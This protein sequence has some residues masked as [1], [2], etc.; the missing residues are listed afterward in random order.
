MASTVLLV[1]SLFINYLANIYTTDHA[2]VYVPDI[3]LDNLPVFNVNFIFYDGFAIFWL[4]VAVLL[5]MNPQKI[6][7]VM[8]STA[9]FILIRSFFI[10]LT[11]LGLPPQHSFL[12]PDSTFRYMT[13][14][15]DMFFSSHTGLPFLMGL[16]FWDNKK[17]RAIFLIASAVF[18]VSV[19]LGHLHYSIDVFAAFFIAY[20]IYHISLKLFTVDYRLFEKDILP[21][22]LAL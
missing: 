8:K 11:H 19:L 5:L 13:S 4:F 12:D 15:N 22:R 18:A 1:A 7:F 21:A 17:L 9:I 2:S 14:G 20:G 10:T 3:L 16:I 6:P